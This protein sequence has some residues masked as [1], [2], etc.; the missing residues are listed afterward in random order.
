MTKLYYLQESTSTVGNSLLFWAKD[1]C[2][3]T[4]DLDKAQV[5]TEEQAMSRHKNRETDI[6]W[7]KEYIDKH[8]QK[9]VNC[10]HVDISKS[11][12]LSGITLIKPKPPKKPI[13]RC[14][15]GK[16]ITAETYYTMQ[17]DCPHY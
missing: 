2:G 10:Q 7:L 3:Y 13:Y 1:D 8:I 5:Y 17:S 9:S 16:F 6:P 11:L 12:K 14:T 15:C 4:T